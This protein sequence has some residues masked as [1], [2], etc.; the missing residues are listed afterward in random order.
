MEVNTVFTLHLPPLHYCHM[1]A[2]TLILSYINFLPAGH[3]EGIWVGYTDSLYSAITQHFILRLQI[4]RLLNHFTGFSCKV[5]PMS[6]SAESKYYTLFPESDD[7]RATRM[8][9]FTIRWCCCHLAEYHKYYHHS[10]SSPVYRKSIFLWEV[11]K[12]A[13]VITLCEKR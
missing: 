11:L 5:S 13:V 12:I 4:T 2:I 1:G 9:V 3:C 8:K 7:D 10:H 6:K